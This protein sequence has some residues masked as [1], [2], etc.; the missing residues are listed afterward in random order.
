MAIN[1]V[2][3]YKIIGVI[4]KQDTNI[5]IEIAPIRAKIDSLFIYPPFS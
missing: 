3:R 1:L 4:I 5:E 2:N